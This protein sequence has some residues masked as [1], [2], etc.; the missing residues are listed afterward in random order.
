MNIEKNI[1]IICKESFRGGLRKS[2]S[3]K[4]PSAL[5]RNLQP[6]LWLKTKMFQAN[7][8]TDG[9][10]WSMDTSIVTHVWLRS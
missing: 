8:N 5:Q 2:G 6:Q 7:A 1:E 9:R 3:P 10:R 4:L